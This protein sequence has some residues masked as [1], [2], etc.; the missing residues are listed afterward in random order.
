MSSAK[1]NKVVCFV[2]IFITNDQHV[3]CTVVLTIVSG[4][5]AIIRTTTNI[6]SLNKVKYKQ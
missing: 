3:I 5:H 2:L 6:K 4:R 1:H